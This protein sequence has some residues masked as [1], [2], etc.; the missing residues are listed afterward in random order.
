MKHW[1]DTLTGLGL[2]HGRSF[3][4]D[5]HTIPF[6]G[7]DALVEKHYVS[8][9]S[10]RQKGILAFLAQDGEQRFFCYA[11]S[12]L[13][14]DQQDDEV[15]AF[16]R[17]W[18][19]RTGDLPEELIFDSRLT[20]HANLN[21]LNQQ[22]V[23]FITLRRRSPQLMHDLLARSP[24]AWR[25]IELAGVS[26]QYKTPRILDDQSDSANHRGRLGP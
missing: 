5:F 10:R 21:H 15:L 22:G 24:S 7:E 3:D 26:R 11:N 16:V 12:D 9:R 8:K 20:T 13:R 23:Q 19:E 18:K 1:F 2:K 4:L 6:H 14:K 25:R 17:F